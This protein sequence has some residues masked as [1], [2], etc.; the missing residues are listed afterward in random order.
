M[1]VVNQSRNRETKGE[2]KKGAP[3]H[4]QTRETQGLKISILK[5]RPIM[6]IAR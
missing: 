2:T 5:D 6:K 3:A 4:R 1:G